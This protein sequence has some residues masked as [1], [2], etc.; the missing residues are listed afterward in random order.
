MLI[1]FLIKK[2][3][4]LDWNAVKW[5]DMLKQISRLCCNPLEMTINHLRHI[6]LKCS[7]MS[8]TVK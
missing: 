7:Y 1:L 6:S 3:R 8:Y 5:R 2:Y 4:H